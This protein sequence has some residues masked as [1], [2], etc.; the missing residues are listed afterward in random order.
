[1]TEQVVI[2]D[3]IARLTVG[4]GTEAEAV[5]MARG[6]LER[7]GWQTGMAEVLGSFVPKI[8]VIGYRA[9]RVRVVVE[10]A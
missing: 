1:M 9:W 10:K 7:R 2:R 3:G 4:A 8:G 6:Y 5:T